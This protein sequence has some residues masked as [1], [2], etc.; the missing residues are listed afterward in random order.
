MAEQLHDLVPGHTHVMVP[1]APIAT[2]RRQDVLMPRKRRDLPLMARHRPQLLATLN[3]PKLD[4]SSANADAEKHP[5]V[6]EVDAGDVGTFGG[7]AEVND[8]ARVGLPD[9][10]RTLERDGD[11]VEAGPRDEV[12]VEIVDH[13][14]CVEDAFGLGG[15]FAGL[16]G[17]GAGGGGECAG[18]G[19]V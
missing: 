19:G 4:F 18:A 10:G 1:D 11:G 12:E 5:V 17:D 15:D 9:V 7:V 6:R 3:V 16:V 2:T 13:A 8:A 14:W